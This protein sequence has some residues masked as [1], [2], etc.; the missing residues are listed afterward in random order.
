MKVGNIMMRQVEIASPDESVEHAA[1]MMAELD[2]GA[3]PVG[4]DDRLVGMVTDRDI[5]IRIVAKGLDAS[6][7]QIREAMTAGIGYCFEDQEVDEIVE[8]MKHEQ[9]RRLPVL[10]RGKRLV[11]ILS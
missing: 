9:V 4:E 11:G 1:R 8:T 7:A 3:L 10:D 6:Q 2:I 5:T